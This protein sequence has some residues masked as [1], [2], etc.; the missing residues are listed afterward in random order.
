[1]LHPQ[2]TTRTQPTEQTRTSTHRRVTAYALAGSAVLV[3]VSGLVSPAHNGDADG[4]LTAATT[5]PARVTA[6]A[7]I[8]I[9]SSA[10]FVVG[11]LGAARVVRGR[12]G[13][14]AVAAAVLGVLGAMGHV[15]AATFA[16][17]TIPVTAAAPPDIAVAVLD[18]VNQ[19]PAIGLVVMP[20]MMAFALTTLLLPLAYYRRR[21]LPL[22]VPGLAGAAVVLELLAPGDLVVTTAGKYALGIAT[23]AAIAWRLNRMSDDE[24]RHP[25]T[26]A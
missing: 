24:W 7:V 21:L 16:L 6:G 11:V 25:E 3:G 5:A 23:M 12:G 9:V 1:M 17:V 2:P 22:W 19:D 20:L 14:V 15:A 4:L 8:L 18:S 10:L 13:R 26:L